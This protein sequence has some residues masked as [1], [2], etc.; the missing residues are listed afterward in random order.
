MSRRRIPLFWSTLV[1]LVLVWFGLQYALP[2]LTMW[3]AG[4]ERPFPV[5]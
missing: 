3:V 5:P 2:Y 1:A 4:G